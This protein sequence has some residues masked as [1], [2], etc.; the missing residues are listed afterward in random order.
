MVLKNKNILIVSPEA[1]GHIFVSKHHY[2]THLAEMGNRVFYLNPPSEGFNVKTTDYERVMEVNAPKFIKG[3]RWFPK[4]LQKIVIAQRWKKLEKICGLK[5]DVIWSFDNSVFF[6]FGALPSRVLKISHI[7][8]LNMD[9]ETAKAAASSDVSFCTTELI[10][11]RL[12]QYTTKVYK[13]N[14]GVLATK[15]AEKTTAIAL[16][17]TQKVKALYVGNLAMRYLDWKIIGE[18]VEQYSTIDF[19]FVGSNAEVFEETINPHHVYKK[20]LAQKDN[21]FFLGKVPAADI[22]KYLKG[23]TVLLVAYQEK[24]HQDQANP[25]KVM[26][27]LASGKPI[28]AT[29]TAEFSNLGMLYM[30]KENKEWIAMFTKVLANLENEQA[31]ALVAEQKAF[32]AQNTYQKQIRRIETIL[33]ELGF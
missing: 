15:I 22:P 11:K 29:Y 17:G 28:I 21:V 4:L 23:A 33:S 19:V 18:A 12:L 6:E 14:H 8:D 27:Y 7:V 32:A 10:K 2:S 5:F 20:A 3:L 31:R 24:Y 26:E 9:F 13:I 25:H 16:P 1:W 30:S